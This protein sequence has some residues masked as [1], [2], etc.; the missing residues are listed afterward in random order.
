MKHSNLIERAEVK[1]EGYTLTILVAAFLVTIIL[2]HVM[3]VATTIIVI[4]LMAE[5]YLLLPVIS[6]LVVAHP[7]DNPD[8]DH[9]HLQLLHSMS[10]APVI[11]RSP[12][13]VPINYCMFV[14]VDYVGQRLRVLEKA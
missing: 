5:V 14:M 3:I 4:N 11:V 10:P 1:V 6:V 8:P 9:V 2:I 7:Q 12:N 13:H